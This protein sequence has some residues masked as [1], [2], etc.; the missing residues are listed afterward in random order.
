MSSLGF[1]SAARVRS[2]APRLAWVA[3]LA[4]VLVSAPAHVLAQTEG[5][6]EAAV[7]SA[8]ADEATRHLHATARDAIGRVERD[9]LSYTALVRQRGGVDLRLPIRDRSL[10]RM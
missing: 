6:S 4:L 5:P 8:F 1:V 10:F 7:S 2:A 9:V 3:T